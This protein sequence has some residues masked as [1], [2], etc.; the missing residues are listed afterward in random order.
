MGGRFNRAGGALWWANAAWS[1]KQA[2]LNPLRSNACAIFPMRP[3]FRTSG[4]T[5]MELILALVIVGILS[6]VVLSKLTPINGQAS[7][8]SLQQ[9]GA[10]LSAGSAINKAS[11]ASRSPWGFAVEEA[12]VCA[13]SSLARFSQQSL[14]ASLSSTAAQAGSASCVDASTAS[15]SCS[16]TLGSEQFTTA[17]A[18][19]RSATP[20]VWTHCANEKSTCSFSGTRYVR[21]G[22]NGSYAIRIATGSI[23]CTNANFGDP[24]FEVVKKCSVSSTPP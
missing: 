21:Y 1:A 3:L 22:A 24:I 10:A 2:R 16:L 17:I 4:F 9:L 5:L 13:L 8:A 11:L 6:T 19:A 15:A 12:D 7:A 23:A 18:C 20:I 14:P